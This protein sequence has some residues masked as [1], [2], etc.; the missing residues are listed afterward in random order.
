VTAST[1]SSLHATTTSIARG[2]NPVG[3]GTASRAAL[4]IAA[5]TVAVWMSSQPSCSLL[6][7]RGR[8]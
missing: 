5:C 7:S 8:T 4:P 3:N 6:R 1:V 2:N